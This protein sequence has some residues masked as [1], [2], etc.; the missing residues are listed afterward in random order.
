[1]LNPVPDL[2]L[3]L[4]LF[5]WSE[6]LG[7]LG[8]VAASRLLFRSRSLVAVGSALVAVGLLLAIGGRLTSAFVFPGLTAFVLTKTLLRNT[9]E[10]FL[11]KELLVSNFIKL[12]HILNVL[13]NIRNWTR[14]LVAGIARASADV[15]F[16]ALELKFG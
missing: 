8:L 11:A 6:G 14:S 4:G 7:P 1:M 12:V 13:S 15:T 16:V 5:A 2:R 10:I 9:L 3:G